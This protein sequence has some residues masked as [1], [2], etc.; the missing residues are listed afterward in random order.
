ME[1]EQRPSP[2]PP[3]PP[4]EPSLAVLAFLEAM[5]AKD[6]R[7]AD[8]AIGGLNEEQLLTGMTTIG[9]T[10]MA[11]LASTLGTTVEHVVDALRARLLSLVA[12][13][14]HPLAADGNRRAR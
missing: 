9:S 5:H 14:V 4:A 3:A 2:P 10:L 8:L 12:I 6:R 1:N 7:A 11:D 13:G